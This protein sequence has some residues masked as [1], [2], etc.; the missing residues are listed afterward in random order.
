MS[1]RRVF[2]CRTLLFISISARALVDYRL[3]Y[4]VERRLSIFSLRYSFSAINLVLL[5]SFTA[6]SS[7]ASFYIKKGNRPNYSVQTV[8]HIII[9]NGIFLIGNTLLKMSTCPHGREIFS[10]FLNVPPTSIILLSEWIN[11]AP[12]CSRIMAH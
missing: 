2:L 11:M 6:V 8:S 10:F 12:C 5:T 7:N 3:F 1:L 4:A 9:L